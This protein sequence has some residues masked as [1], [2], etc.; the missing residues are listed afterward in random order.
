MGKRRIRAFA[1]ALILF[2]VSV[3][4]GCEDREKPE[5]VPS[6]SE[7][8]G[9]YREETSEAPEVTGMPVFK[10]YAETD[11]KDVTLNLSVVDKEP[12]VEVTSIDISSFDFGEK[13]PVCNK[14][15]FVEDYYNKREERAN[16]QLVFQWQNFVDKPVKGVPTKCFIWNDKC[17]IYVMYDNLEVF[18]WELYSYDMAGGEPEKI[19]SWSAET[20]DE[21]SAIEVCFEDGAMFCYYFKNE[22]NDNLLT[23]VRRVDL[24][25]GKET[26][27]Y[28]DK[29]IDVNIW[30]SRDSYGIILL[31][32]YH[33]V[34]GEPAVSYIYNSREG[35][36]VKNSEIEAPEGKIIDS[37]L[38][39]GINSYLVKREGK[40]KL[41]L[42]ND[43]YSI[44]T[45]F[46]AGRIIYAD[47]GIAVLYDNV[48]L[49]IYDLK[50]MEHRITNIDG[51]G[52]EIEMY[53]GMLFI[54]NRG[55]NFKMPV[56]CIIPELGIT[57]PIVS[58]G[59]YSDLSITSDSLT[60]NE[61]S[62]QTEVIK[63]GAVFDDENGEMQEEYAVMDENGGI[64]YAYT[65]DYTHQYERIDK[66][67]IVKK[68]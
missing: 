38:L 30:L 42:V 37:Y 2:A 22:E 29:G 8:V 6:E 46:T 61:T 11:F 44:P 60:F 12:P 3:N 10:E 15:E 68:K 27:V 67:Y 19:C 20:P 50:K 25:T 7:T 66:I 56:Y 13:V 1:A 14:A 54:G 32:E 23:Q 9:D 18:D 58:D 51:Y 24:E 36:F 59:I 43:L 33:N 17:Y 48:K 5:P 26:V 40:R 35:K 64:S 53:N 62:R 28:E 45:A 65:S 49:H 55:N 34:S 41:E 4:M 47:N 52:N 63:T 57:Y 21:H 31:M 16:G 39:N